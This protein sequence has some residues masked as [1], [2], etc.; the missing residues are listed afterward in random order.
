MAEVWSWVVERYGDRKVLG[1]RD[2]LGQDDEVQPNG[3]VFIK[4]RLGEYR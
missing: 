1:T 2:V 3:T 4:L